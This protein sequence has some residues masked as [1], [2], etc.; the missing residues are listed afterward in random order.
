MVSCSIRSIIKPL[1][2]LSLVPLRK[3]WLFTCSSPTSSLWVEALCLSAGRATLELLRHPQ[4]PKLR[5]PLRVQPKF[6]PSSMTFTRSSAKNL[7]WLAPNMGQMMCYCSPARRS[8][9]YKSVLQQVPPG[10]RGLGKVPYRTSG[11]WDST[12]IILS[13]ESN[14]N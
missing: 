7:P 1:Q 14:I 2:S 6:P 8:S 9:S 10:E 5:W 12:A 4:L 11:R 13:D 3:S